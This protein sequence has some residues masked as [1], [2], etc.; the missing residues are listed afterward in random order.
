MI[1]L[2]K[3][4]SLNKT[5][6]ILVMISGG[7]GLSSQTL[8][9]MDILKSDFNLIYVDFPGTNGNP[10]FKKQSFEELLNSLTFTLK[11]EID[12][13][14]SKVIVLGHSFGGFFAA[15]LSSRILLNGLVCVSTPFSKESLSVASVNYLNYQSEPLRDAELKW[16]LNKNDETLKNWFSEYGTLYF[17]D[18]QKGKDLILSD[19]VSSEF[20]ISNRSDAIK[21]E[22]LLEALSSLKIKKLYIAGREDGLLPTSSL[23]RDAIRGNFQFEVVSDASHFVTFDQ[24]KSVAGLIKNV[25]A[26]S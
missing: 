7:P 1:K 5:D 15:A 4:D 9:S 12:F 14:K 17:K 6:N 8:R 16:E 11:S 2:T 18:A 26:T 21:M 19:L 22:S 20:F 25:F 13:E 3:V 10:Y 23:E 24:P